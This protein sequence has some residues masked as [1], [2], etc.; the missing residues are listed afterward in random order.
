MKTTASRRWSP[1]Q[2]GKYEGLS[3][4]QIVLKDPDYFFWAMEE[5]PL[6]D[7]LEAIEVYEK[8]RRIIPI[9]DGSSNWRVEYCYMG[10]QG[11]YGFELVEPT[12]PRH[13]GSSTT[14]RRDYIDLAAARAFKV[15]DK[16]GGKMLISS[17]KETVFGNA[18]IRFTK[19]VA[20]EFFS[21]EENFFEYP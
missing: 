11:F 18:S 1:V 7:N 15:Y 8:A 3:A 6:K 2:F 13:H 16:T 5:T 20:E 10:P 19:R 21:T 14:T 4:P 9:R 17:L 12:R